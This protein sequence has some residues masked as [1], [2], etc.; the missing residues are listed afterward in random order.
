MP[1]QL[2]A[3]FHEQRDHVFLK[4]LNSEAHDSQSLSPIHLNLILPHFRM[5]KQLM[6]ITIIL[7]IQ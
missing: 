4:Q 1:L 7:A 2:K 3:I 5:I 6:K